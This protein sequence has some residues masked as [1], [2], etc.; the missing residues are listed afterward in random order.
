MQGIL[1]AVAPLRCPLWATRPRPAPLPVP[2]T[3]PVAVRAAAIASM[4]VSTG[5]A[6]RPVW[7]D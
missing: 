6:A 5:V 2:R 7:A 1:P 3:Q 4:P